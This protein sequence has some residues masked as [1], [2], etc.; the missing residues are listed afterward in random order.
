M[1]ISSLVTQS[2]YILFACILGII[3]LILLL[4]PAIYKSY[5]KSHFQ[6][7][8]YR[9]IHNL[10]MYYDYYL[11]N[12]FPLKKGEDLITTLD[13]VLI[14]NKYIYVIKDRYYQE[15]ISASVNDMVWLA[16]N[17]KGAK[18]EFNN[19]IMMNNIRCDKFSN[20]KFIDRK[21]LISIVVVNDDA[22]VEK[23]EELNTFNSFFVRKKDLKK[24]IKT[25]E[26][27]NVSAF[28]AEALD[29]KVMD[30]W[31]DTGREF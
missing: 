18:T 3:I 11:I 30:I 25:I 9:K 23:Q 1:L 28:N 24:L 10:V 16:Y 26:K 22:Y 31:K 15:P 12:N 5:S 13:H 17:K 20:I 27:R 21:C 8:V 14:S 19:P 6:K 2:I 29:K 4:M 7:M